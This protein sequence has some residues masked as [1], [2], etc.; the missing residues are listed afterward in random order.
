MCIKSNYFICIQF[1]HLL[2]MNEN[3]CA[4]EMDMLVYFCMKNYI[5]DEI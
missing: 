2:K 5:L 4:N 1:Y 3:V